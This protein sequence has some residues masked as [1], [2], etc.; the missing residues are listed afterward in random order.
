M[1]NIKKGDVRLS[2]IISKKQKKNQSPSMRSTLGVA[3]V[4]NVNYEEYFVTLR[5]ILGNDFEN[6][7]IP[8]PLTF[9]GAGTRHF[10]GAMPTVGDYCVCGWFAQDSIGAG[11]SNPEATK[12]PV[13]LAWIPRGAWLGHDWVFTSPFSEDEREMSQKQQD[14][15]QGIYTQ[16]RHKRLHMRP[17]DVV[18]SSSKGSDILLNEGVYI[19]NRRANEIRLRDQDQAFVVRSQQQFHIMSGAKVYGGMIQRDSRLLQGAVANRDGLNRA[20]A[21]QIDSEGNPIKVEDL[22]AWI[23]G[24]RKRFAPSIE[25]IGLDNNLLPTNILSQ[26]GLFLVE[27]NGSVYGGKPMFRVAIDKNNETI[28][29]TLGKEIPTFTEY[30]IELSH[31]SDGLLPVSEQTEG[32]D[33]DK[34]IN[35]VELAYGTVVGNDPK[36]ESDLYGKPLVADVFPEPSISPITERHSLGDH[37]ASLFKINAIDNT[38]GLLE[39]TWFAVNKDGRVKVSIGGR[40][41]TNSLD[42]RV[43][44]HTRVDFL[45]GLTLNLRAPVKL[46]S[47]DRTDSRNVGVEVLSDN[48][49]VVIQ[50]KG[51]MLPN[52]AE[53]VNP[54]GKDGNPQVTPSVYITSPNTKIEGDST[55]EM[56]T[57]QATLQATERID[58]ESGN[59][60]NMVVGD[61]IIKAQ[62][63]QWDQS[64][65][66]Q[67]TYKYA[68]PLA[69]QLGLPSNQKLPLRSTTFQSS[70][71]Q[72]LKNTV[73]S[74]TYKIGSREETFN[75]GDH[76][77]T[78]KVGDMT[79]TMNI[80]KHTIKAGTT[81]QEISPTKYS[82]DV[83]TGSISMKSSATATFQG[84]AS[85]LV[86]S[87]GPATVKGSVVTLSTGTGI[88]KGILSSATINP[89]NG[90]PF[91]SPT[92]GV[93][94]SKK[95][96]IV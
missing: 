68:G 2:G 20:Q 93:Q 63:K 95:H 11:L 7:R 79:Y 61:G 69:N 74:T 18:A 72:V 41:D 64:T 85:V 87:T 15:V 10:L 4:I 3:Q 49:A 48:G 9:P 66:G 38:Q 24:G 83:P 40:K 8:V 29:N 55:I 94:G 1:D 17:G 6:E 60:I 43:T 25:Q 14:E 33:Q 28:D 92:N 22:S 27:D 19:T 62:S 32:L 71:P 5:I 77:T 35:L 86:S 34:E 50:A 80:G 91:G 30:R 89:L 78:M 42:L 36:N 54:T 13:I 59:A 52:N 57:K 75:I 58:I 65:T 47:S 31:Y 39:P 45:G 26:S 51:N 96:F 23:F 12:T 44:G 56:N 73:D 37:L 76:S 84:T 88:P 46:K 16:H 21:R 53:I 90:Q 70:A 81:E 67:A 82:V